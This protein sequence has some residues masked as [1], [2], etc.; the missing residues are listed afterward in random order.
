MLRTPRGKKLLYRTGNL[1]PSI[2]KRQQPVTKDQTNFDL[3]RSRLHVS[4]IPNSLPCREKEFSNIYSYI[5]GKLM[6]GSGGCIYISGV[7]GTGKK[8]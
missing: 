5:M 3:I 1:T 7:P 2:Q 6:D 8:V 4:A